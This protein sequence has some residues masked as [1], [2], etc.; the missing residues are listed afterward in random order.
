M[1][2]PNAL[3]YAI[4]VCTGGL[5]QRHQKQPAGPKGTGRQF[6]LKHAYDGTFGTLVL[7][8]EAEPPGFFGSVSPPLA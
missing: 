2:R 1:V 4:M 5:E 6:F 8:P 7:R 3:P